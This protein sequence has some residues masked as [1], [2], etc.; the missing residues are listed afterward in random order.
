MTR[1]LSLSPPAPG[2]RAGTARLLHL[3]GLELAPELSS[4]W[5]LPGAG[6]FG[7]PVKRYHRASLGSPHAAATANVVHCVVGVA[8]S[9]VGSLD[10]P[11]PRISTEGA[12]A[13]AAQE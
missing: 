4:G 12:E 7:W 10:A 1:L 8:G 6:S 13:S 5:S 2:Q 11:A 9:V 3:R